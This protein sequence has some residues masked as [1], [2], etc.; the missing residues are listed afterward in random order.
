MEQLNDN[1]LGPLPLTQTLEP[2]YELLDTK[3]VRDI[4]REDTNEKIDAENVL[5]QVVLG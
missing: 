4:T 3:A 2:I 1:T 5:K